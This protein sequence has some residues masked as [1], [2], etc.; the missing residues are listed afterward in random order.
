MTQQPLLSDDAAW[1]AF[2]ARD[3]A[4]EDRFVVAVTTTG[5]YCKPTCPARRP[6]RAHVRFLPDVAA[7]QASGFRA[8]LRCKPDDVARE[9]VAV[10]KAV[11][12]LDAAE[13]PVT[14][15]LLAEA[16]GYAPHHFQR[17]FKR[18][19]G[20]SPAAYARGLRARRA[21][22]ALNAQGSVTDAIYAA[23]YSAPSRFYETAP[24]RLGMTP[25]AWRRG[26]AGVT[27]HWTVAST[28]L[29]ALLIA[30]TEK[31]LCRVAFGEDEAALSRRFPAAEIVP[32]G[33]A[34]KALAA[35]VVAEVETPG[36]DLGL[37]LD[38]QGT[39]FQEAVWQA[40]RAIPPGQ[41]RSY[42]QL[43]A[44]AGRPG[45]VRAAG[46]A[47][48]ANHV[49][50]LIPCHRAQRG[51]GSMGGYAYGIDRKRILRGR[52]GVKD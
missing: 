12:L 7:A 13:E 22:A 18:A 11:S 6:K 39:A 36:R 48:G 43:A 30:A 37:P 9:R 5:I 52:E 47:C 2:E 1:A 35:Q 38:V 41:T 33:E 29:G 26:G 46:T 16:V 28:S 24:A 21:A 8:C 19:T 4:Y 50:V 15:D 14:L 51:D 25:S 10:A 34:L 42:S 27:I 49:A 40:L 3:R 32:G 23:G 44:E 31:G 20:V 17:L 45:A